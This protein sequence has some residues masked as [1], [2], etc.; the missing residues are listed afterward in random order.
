MREKKIIDH[1]IIYWRVFIIII[2]IPHRINTGNFTFIMNRKKQSKNIIIEQ[3]YRVKHGLV[4][5]SLSIFENYAS[6]T[7]QQ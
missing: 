6:Y 2:I 5:C 1:D 3:F 7:V 4:L